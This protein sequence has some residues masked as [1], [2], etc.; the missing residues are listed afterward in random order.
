M[1]DNVLLQ[2]LPMHVT[3]GSD[4]IDRLIGRRRVLGVITEGEQGMNLYPGPRR[5]K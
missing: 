3:E 4:Q 1:R 2:R 5:A